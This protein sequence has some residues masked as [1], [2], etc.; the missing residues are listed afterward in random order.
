[1]K[2]LKH[3]ETE[4]HM[5]QKEANQHYEQIEQMLKETAASVSVP[6]EAV[7]ESSNRINSKAEWDIA[8]KMTRK[9]LEYMHTLTDNEEWADL[10]LAKIEEMRLERKQKHE[11]AYTSKP[12]DFSVEKSKSLLTSDETLRICPITINDKNSFCRIR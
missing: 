9:L 1:M 7:Q 2:E 5:E 8:N 10:L 12:W 4:G 6:S 11:R 3:F